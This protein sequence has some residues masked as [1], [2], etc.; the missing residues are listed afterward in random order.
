[1]ILGAFVGMQERLTQENL[2]VYLSHFK[3]ISNIVRWQTVSH[4]SMAR[5][6]ASI[7]A[8]SHG[9]QAGAEELAELRFHER[10]LTTQKA[11]A[12]TKSLYKDFDSH[13]LLPDW[14]LSRK[15]TEIRPVFQVE[16]RERCCNS[17]TILE[18][19]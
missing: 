1:M 17:R 7:E 11:E 19:V 15:T 5:L 12:T 6:R 9:V 8:F 3:R 10:L 13:S 18:A 14:Q 2:A 4:L 16:F